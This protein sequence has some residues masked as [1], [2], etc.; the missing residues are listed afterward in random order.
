MTRNGPD[1]PYNTQARALQS[2]VNKD[3][4]KAEEICAPFVSYLLTFAV[5][6][7]VQR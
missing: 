5:A 7:R 2:A 1:T 4:A 6:E 3:K